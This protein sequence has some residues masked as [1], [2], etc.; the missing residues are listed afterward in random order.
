VIWPSISGL[1][2][3][4]DV[5]AV[6]ERHGFTGW[7]TYPVEL[8]G[9]DDALIDGYVG[10]AVTGR[11]GAIDDGLC[12]PIWQEYPGGIFAEWRGMFF[13]PATWDGSDFFTPEGSYHPSILVTEDVVHALRKARVS[14]VDAE[15]LDLRPGPDWHRKPFPPSIDGV[16]VEG[17]QPA[18]TPVVDPYAWPERDERFGAAVLRV[19]RGWRENEPERDIGA[20]WSY[21]SVQR[22]PHERWDILYVRQANLTDPLDVAAASEAKDEWQALVDRWR[23]DGF[24]EDEE[25]TQI[26]ASELG[27]V[28]AWRWTAHG[29][30]AS[31]PKV[32]VNYLVLTPRWFFFLSAYGPCGSIGDLDPG[33]LGLLES[34]RADEPATA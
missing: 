13:D 20:E 32:G 29:T 9:K 14:N 8:H 28:F 12:V 11:C 6:L 18:G 16:A 10:I 33:L 25:W 23:A 17:R 31:K 19:P 26:E 4:A 21:F 2:V 1:V 24:A 27:G 34:F 3:R 15:R 5:I 30:R 22:P 7:A